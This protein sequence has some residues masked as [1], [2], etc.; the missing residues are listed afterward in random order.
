[1][2]VDKEILKNNFHKP[3]NRKFR[4][5]SEVC[6]V[7]RPIIGW[8][9]KGDEYRIVGGT[10]YVKV[11]GCYEIILSSVDRVHEIWS[12]PAKDLTIEELRCRLEGPLEAC[13]RGLFGRRFL[14]KY[15]RLHSQRRHPLR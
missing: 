14:K 11:D 2:P 10:S 15:E 8:T 12:V 13:K 7:V 5:Y 4:K 1:M 9:R 6:G 3:N